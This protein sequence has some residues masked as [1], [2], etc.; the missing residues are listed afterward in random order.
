[1]EENENKKGFLSSETSKIYL[2]FISILICVFCI[3]LCIGDPSW[4]NNYIPDNYFILFFLLGLAYVLYY[5]FS[6]FRKPNPEKKKM[7]P[8]I[9]W[10]VV[11]F[12]FLGLSLPFH[13]VPEKGMMFPKEHLTFSN[14]II[15]SSDINELIERYNNASFI[16]KRAIREEPLVR[17]L[18]EKGLIH[19]K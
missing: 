16:E 4:K 15:T 13:Y 10:G 1:M 7:N 5:I 2:F 11:V 3:Y 9:K 19:E 14:T 18:M 8:Y 6:A 17:K 12:I